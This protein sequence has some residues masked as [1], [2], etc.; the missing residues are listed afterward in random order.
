MAASTQTRISVLSHEK[1]V[2]LASETGRTHQEVI[3]IALR[4]YERELFLERLNE[5]FARLR[6]DQKA[7]E[8]EQAERA[9]WDQTLTDGDAE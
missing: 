2:R 4:R 1:L 7:W 9:D 6:S 8:Q 3:D 5:G